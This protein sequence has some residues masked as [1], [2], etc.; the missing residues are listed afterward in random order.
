MAEKRLVP[1]ESHVGGTVAALF[2]APV[3]FVVA[4]GIVGALFGLLQM[5]FSN[6]SEWWTMTMVGVVQAVTGTY[7]AR[8]A[9]DAVLRSYS[10]R[11]VFI[12]FVIIVA[13]LILVA[14]VMLP[15]SWK[16]IPSLI[17]FAVI[18]GVGWQLLWKGED[19]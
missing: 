13:V 6:D 4:G 9:C 11:A 16:R 2:I 12:E 1:D 5:I 17:E 14:F 10:L 18:I 19:L 8:T 3:V 15:W 7:A